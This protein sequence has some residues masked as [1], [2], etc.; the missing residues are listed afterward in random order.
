MTSKSG[1]IGS[2]K[3]SSSSG[4][5]S[6]SSASRDIESRPFDTMNNVISRLLLSLTASMR[7]PVRC[8]IRRSH[9][10]VCQHLTCDSTFWQGSLN[11]DLNEITM[12]L[13]PFPR[14]NFL[15]SSCSPL[16]GLSSTGSAVQVCSKGYNCSEPAACDCDF[17][18]MAQQMGPRR[19]EASFLEPFDR[20]HQ[21]LQLEPRHRTYLAAGLLEFF[22]H[23]HFL[24]YTIAEKISN[25]CVLV[26]FLPLHSTARPW[27]NE[28]FRRKSCHR[29]AEADVENGE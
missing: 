27:G 11:T 26:C 3:G 19:L 12:N 15:L 28:H 21:M 20:D 14:L 9:H 1:G 23:I 13:V 29:E 6:S 24:A 18:R 17:V 22:R 25:K 2:K 7:F 5:G 10:T 16:L 8:V 4:G